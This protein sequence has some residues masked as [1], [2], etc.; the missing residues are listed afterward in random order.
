MGWYGWNPRSGPLSKLPELRGLALAAVARMPTAFLAGVE[1]NLCPDDFGEPFWA[2]TFFLDTFFWLVC[3]ADFTVFFADGF[4]D[5]LRAVFLTE[6]RGADLEARF[7]PTLLTLPL[8]LL[9]FVAAFFAAIAVGLQDDKN[10]SAIIH[11]R[12]PRGSA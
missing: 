7:F 10:E 9:F 5:A 4:L 12:R 2:G 6:R 11:T 1:D 3:L 8:G